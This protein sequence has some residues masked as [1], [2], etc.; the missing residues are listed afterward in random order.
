MSTS[1]QLQ[2]QAREIIEIETS[3]QVIEIVDSSAKTGTVNIKCLTTLHN[4]VDI[5]AIF[6]K[7]RVIL[8]APGMGTLLVKRI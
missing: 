6:S 7:G 1:K 3:Y 8:E 2:K 5:R 4:I